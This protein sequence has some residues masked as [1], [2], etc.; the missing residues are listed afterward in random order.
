MSD[1][2][3]LDVKIETMNLL[4]RTKYFY[5]QYWKKKKKN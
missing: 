1:L 2:K 4:E 5:L 3:E